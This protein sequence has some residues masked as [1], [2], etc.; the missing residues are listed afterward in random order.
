MEFCKYCGRELQ[1]GSSCNCP[2]SLKA[3]LDENNVLPDKSEI[4]KPVGQNSAEEISPSQS[5]GKTKLEK[6]ETKPNQP[7]I[8]ADTNP[9]PEPS[10][11]PVQRQTSPS[12][13]GLTVSSDSDFYKPII[14]AAIVLLVLLILLKLAS[15]SGYKSTTKDYFK[16]RYSKHGGRDYYSLILPDDAIDELKDDDEWKE[17]VEDYN[18][19]V[20]NRMDDWDKK[21]KFKKISKAKKMKN[22]ELKKAEQFF[23]AAAV[24]CGADIDDDEIEA[25]KGYAV[26]YKYKNTEGD[27]EKSTIYVVK[28]K[29]EGW[30]VMNDLVTSFYGLT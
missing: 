20:E 19:D 8:S 7:D 23:Y 5:S 12:G 27:N 24:A 18:D 16:S 28:I 9:Q 22:S 29:G 13:N 1:D 11:A 30:K 26:T 21:P 25:K 15:G 2:D 4:T 6:Q 17:L 10:A 14:I 3:K